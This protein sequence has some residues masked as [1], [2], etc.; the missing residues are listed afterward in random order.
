[1]GIGITRSKREDA[2]EFYNLEAKCSDM[3]GNH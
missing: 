3:D 1:M 2:L